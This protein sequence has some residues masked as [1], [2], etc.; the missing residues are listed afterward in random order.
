MV[1]GRCH[2]QIWTRSISP[3]WPSEPP[4]SMLRQRR[5]QPENGGVLR[6]RQDSATRFNEGL[7]DQTPR[8]S[9]A[10]S[11]ASSSAPAILAP[12]TPPRQQRAS[13]QRPSLRAAVTAGEDAS[14]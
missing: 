10:F 12:P 13:S 4:I 9:P 5:A 11:R 3:P 2:L 14:D 6:P 1:V 7:P 8:G